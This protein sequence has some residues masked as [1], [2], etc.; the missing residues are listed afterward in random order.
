[1]SNWSSLNSLDSYIG[2]VI[3]Q[4]VISDATKTFGTLAAEVMRRISDVE[5]S[6]GSEDHIAWN[7]TF[8]ECDCRE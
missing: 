6:I 8:G 4:P 5:P 3:F 1:M 2:T 7:T